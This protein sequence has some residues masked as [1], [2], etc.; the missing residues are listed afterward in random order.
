MQLFG[1]S[2]LWKRS[3]RR[4]LLVVTEVEVFYNR[5]GMEG[6]DKQRVVY[7]EN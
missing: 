7:L 4:P 1:K 2:W 3:G 5:K 6:I